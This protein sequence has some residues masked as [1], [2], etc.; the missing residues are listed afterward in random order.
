MNPITEHFKN[1]A[2]K[3]AKKKNHEYRCKLNDFPKT[4]SE[5]LDALFGNYRRRFPDYQSWMVPEVYEDLIR[6]RILKKQKIEKSVLQATLEKN[7]VEDVLARKLKLE[8]R[9]KQKKELKDYNSEC[10]EEQKE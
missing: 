5:R 2:I 8:L 6:N 7:K 9:L 3:N 10:K 4:D 1:L